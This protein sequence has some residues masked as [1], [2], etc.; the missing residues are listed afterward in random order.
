VIVEIVVVV[1]ISMLS[2]SLI[3]WKGLRGCRLC[4]CDLGVLS[5]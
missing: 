4:I 3:E 1:F 5:G 2:L